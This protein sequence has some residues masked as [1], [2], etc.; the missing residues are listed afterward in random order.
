[1]P[2]PLSEFGWFGTR[3]VPQGETVLVGLVGE[4]IQASRTPRMHEMSAATL[5]F[6]LVYRLFDTECADVPST[7]LGE[8]LRAAEVAGFAGLNI[9]HPFKLAVVDHLDALDDTAARVGAVN[10][11][12]FGGGRRIGFNTD[13]T[14]FVAGFSAGLG[15][16]P[17][18]RVLLVGAG[19]GGVAVAHALAACGVRR[20][21][22]ADLDPKRLAALA[23]RLARNHPELDV[24]A[25]EDLGPTFEASLDGIVNAT[26]VGMAAHPGSAVPP[27]RLDPR[28]WVSDIIYFPLETA[29]LAA[30]RAAGCRVLPG[31]GMAIGQAV[32]AFRHFTGHTADRAAM[33]AAFASF[34]R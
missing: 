34:D 4:G 29:L 30:A 25:T 16:A 1:M 11:V 7:D 8:I 33:E 3:P 18:E 22:I 32:D 23:D 9:T 17:H 31:T 14:G 12:V 6:R 19:G 2:V 24:T 21:V 26:P 5:G 28:T 20:L 13:M 27:E 15:D 10:T